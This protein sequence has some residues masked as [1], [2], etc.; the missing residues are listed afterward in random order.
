VDGRYVVFGRWKFA[1]GCMGA[2][3]IG[4][5]LVDEAAPGLPRGLLLRPGQVTIVKEWM[6]AV[7]P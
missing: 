2:D 4:V 5:G 1:S 7:L 6:S 3:Y